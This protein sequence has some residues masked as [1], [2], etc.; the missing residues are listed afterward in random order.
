MHP[1][2]ADTPGRWKLKF[3]CEKTK[4]YLRTVTAQ[5]ADTIL[6]AA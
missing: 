1:G 6:W 5:G 4:C 2:W 3:L